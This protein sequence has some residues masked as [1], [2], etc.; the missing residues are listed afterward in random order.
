MI[1]SHPNLRELLPE[2]SETSVN[3]VRVVS[4]S[5]IAL[6]HR[7]PNVVGVHRTKTG[8][9]AGTLIVEAEENL[10]VNQN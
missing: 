2:V 10:N 3:Y 6:K 9:W 4:F 8:Q 1:Y 7:Y 5:E